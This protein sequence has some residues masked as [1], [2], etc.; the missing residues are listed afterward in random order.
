MG[1]ITQD[2]LK[3]VLR[4]DPETGLFTWLVATGRRMR[5]G[6]VAGTKSS[7]GYIRIAVDGKIYR[8]HRLAFLYMTGEWPHDQVD[9]CD[10]D[11]TNNR[12]LNLRPASNSQNAANKRATSSTGYKGVYKNGIGYA[13]Q[14]TVGGKNIYLGQFSTPEQASAAYVAAANDN[15]GEFARAA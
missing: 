15:F 8:A 5:V 13:A 1:A 9:H 2:R 11:R 10:T 7:E 3:E 6:S 14:I 4:Y 12:W